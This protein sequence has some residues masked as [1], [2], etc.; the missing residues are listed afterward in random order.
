[1]GKSSR[2]TAVNLTNALQELDKSMQD[3]FNILGNTNVEDTDIKKTAKDVLCKVVLVYSEFMM[4]RDVNDNRA[5][6]KLGAEA[7]LK[8]T[9]KDKINLVTICN[10][11][12]LATAGFG[13]ALGVARSLQAMDRLESISALETRPYN[14]GSRLTAYEI[15]EEKMNGFLICDSMAGALMKIKGVDVCVVGADRISAN[16]DTANKIGTYNLAIIAAAH[17]VPFYV[18]APFTTI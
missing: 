9:G 8:K 13:T 18:A 3:T 6:G 7:I 12:S 16:G 1:M 17:D 5:I 14:Q 2:P 15:T 4:E 11:G 10:T